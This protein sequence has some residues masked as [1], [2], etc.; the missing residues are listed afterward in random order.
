MV[1]KRE[2]LC[3]RCG[4]LRLDAHK[5]LEW[6]NELYCFMRGSLMIHGLVCDRCNISLKFHQ[7]VWCAS[8]WS[9]VQ[10]IPYYEWEHEYII[11]EKIIEGYNQKKEAKNERVKN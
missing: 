6:S 11:N 3:H 1:M 8:Y 2:L 10:G 5:K 4:L 9:K 7:T